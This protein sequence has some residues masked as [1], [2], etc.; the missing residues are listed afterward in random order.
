MKSQHILEMLNEGKI[1]E[2]KSLLT[3]EIYKS[4]MQGKGGKVNFC[5][6]KICWQTARSTGGRFEQW[7][8]SQ[9]F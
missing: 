3:D 7:K 1:E 2:L 5:F 9:V 8:H 6:R 4:E